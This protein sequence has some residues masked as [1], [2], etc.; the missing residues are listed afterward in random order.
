M[1]KL[2]WQNGKQVF[3]F[4]CSRLLQNKNFVM[5]FVTTTFVKYNYVKQQK[6]DKSNPDYAQTCKR[7]MV[8]YNCCN[9]TDPKPF[10]DDSIVFSH[11]SEIMRT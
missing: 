3:R 2:R 7:F 10:N 4:W 8:I 6:S 5:Q 1:L 9:N 11:V